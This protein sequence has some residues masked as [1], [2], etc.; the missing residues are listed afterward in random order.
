MSEHFEYLR[1]FI[2]SMDNVGLLDHVRS[3]VNHLM[4]KAANNICHL[5]YL[6]LARKVIHIEF[7]PGQDFTGHRQFAQ[8]AF[9]SV[10]FKRFIHV[11]VGDGTLG[12]THF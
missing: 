3:Q 8:V 1:Q 2:S 4:R 12:L 7:V 10:F 5:R 11:I 9:S 6:S